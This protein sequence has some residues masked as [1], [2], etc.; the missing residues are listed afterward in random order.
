MMN[1]MTAWPREVFYYGSPSLLPKPSPLHAGPLEMIY[2][3]GCIRQIKCGNDEI[4]RMIYSAVRDQD[5]NTLD[6]VIENE[7][8]NIEADCF[9]ISYTATYQDVFRAN[10]QFEG[11]SGGKIT[12]SMD[13]TVIKDFRKNRIG[14]C[15]L[16]PVEECKGRECIINY[17][18][19]DA[20]PG[21]FPETIVPYAP[22]KNIR[23]MKWKH[24]NEIEVSIDFDGEVF[25]MED[26]RNWTDASFKT[27][28]TPLDRPYPVL[29][30]KGSTI[31]QKVT[32]SLQGYEK[33]SQEKS[34]KNPR[35]SFDF[36]Q[37]S[38]LPAIG[39]CESSEFNELNKE[40]LKIIRKILPDHYRCDIHTCKA[41]AGEKLE[42]VFRE[43]EQIGTSL[44]LCLHFS[45]FPQTELDQLIG[46]LKKNVGRI[47][48]LVLFREKQKTTDYEL[49][50]TLLPS[51]RKIFP[52]ILIGAGTD[53]F[54][55]ELN[56][57]LIDTKEFDFVIYSLNP[58]V[59]ASDNQSLIENAFAQQYTVQSARL[60]AGDRAVNVSPVSLKMR[61]NPYAIGEQSG[62]GPDKLRGRVD[63]RQMSLFNLGWTV[64][65]L[66]SLT[67]ANTTSI[68]YFETIGACG[69]IQGLSKSQFPGRFYSLPGML[70]PVYHLFRII[71]KN[72]GAKVYFYKPGDD[73][74]S[75]AGF[76]LEKE[77]ESTALV[78]NLTG[79]TKDFHFNM[80]NNYH[81]CIRFNT[82]T[83]PKFAF[84]EDFTERR[85]DLK[86]S[87]HVLELLPYETI[88]LFKI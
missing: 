59:H 66:A 23:N 17:G 63:S 83:F 78:S 45:A 88:V 51:L 5:W 14:F 47:R 52:D 30:K 58:Q 26:Q 2:E 9:N 37:Y 21:T 49:V 57:Y 39:I 64:S 77:V 61:F 60:L 56:M 12:F 72:K 6:Y 36:A 38:V 18:S 71:G 62:D 32:F 68:T 20:V 82:C 73:L 48:R 19:E 70:Y 67:R 40:E 79:T 81:K 75:V 16:H 35:L 24:Q 43:A 34:S 11:T 53:A 1:K 85:E 13:G 4:I 50:Q 41:E 84:D 10:F 55:A 8:L 31:R 69:I 54:F 3:K 44:E 22:F 87:G 15:V 74:F 42:R 65:S 7:S 76:I 46:I 27:F 28:C 25:E 29:V 86:I 33:P 80:M